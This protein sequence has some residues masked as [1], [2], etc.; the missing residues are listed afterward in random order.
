MML[1]HMRHTEFPNTSRYFVIQVDAWLEITETAHR[2]L[3]L[4]HQAA[5]CCTR[6]NGRS[7]SLCKVLDYEK[8]AADLLPGIPFTASP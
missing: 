4:G 8:S 3:Q 6:A 7:D 1:A 2:G 5:V